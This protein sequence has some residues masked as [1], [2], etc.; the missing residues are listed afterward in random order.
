[1]KTAKPFWLTRVAA[2]ALVLSFF[3]ACDDTTEPAFELDPE[4]TAGILDDLVADYLAQNEA[5]NSM[6]YFSE[7]IGMAIGGGLPALAESP[8]QSAAPAKIPEILQGVT[9]V[10]DDLEGGY[11]PSERTGAPA[12]GVRFIL[13]AVNPI[14]G[15]PEEPFNEIGHLEVTDDSTWP[16]LDIGMAAVIGGETLIAGVVT[17]YLGDVG[18]QWIGVDGY[19]SD[20]TGELEYSLYAN[21]EGQMDYGLVYG[22]FEAFW[23][24]SYGQLGEEIEATFTDGTN[25]LVFTLGI[26]EGTITEGSGI[27]FNGETVA[28][29]EGYIFENE[30]LVTITNAAGDPLTAAELAAL[31]DVFGVMDDLGGFMDGLFEFAF[32]MAYLAMPVT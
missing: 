10:W 5:A 17:G 6:E 25:T 4:S 15:V 12:N 31:E 19:L 21:E 24:M 28:V 14:T 1:V 8:W 2:V 20:G 32:M 11:L 22:N 7:Y 27:T 3:A 30:I 9:F 23:S 13:Y 16:S 18:L 29:I 26:L